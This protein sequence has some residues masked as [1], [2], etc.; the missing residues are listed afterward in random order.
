MGAYGEADY[1]EKELTA[2]HEKE[3]SFEATPPEFPPP[4]EEH[5]VYQQLAAEL[6]PAASEQV[7][8][9]LVD[10][11]GAPDRIETAVHLKEIMKA[12]EVGEAIEGELEKRHEIKDEAGQAGAF[13][14]S[15]GQVLA[16]IHQQTQAAHAVQH[17]GRMPAV[18]GGVPS[19]ASKLPLIRDL[20]PMYQ[21]A[22]AG[23]LVGGLLTILVFM[24]ITMK[25]LAR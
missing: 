21:R 18:S 9:E 6:A 13:A 11:P 20:S 15:V 19:L 2:F 5:L 4:L 23:G 17:G 14:A 3:A 8:I 1:N 25:P 24:L 22:L 12:A 16:Q 10:E 7:A